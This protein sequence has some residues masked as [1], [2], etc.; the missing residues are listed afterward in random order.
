MLTFVFD[1]CNS[2]H[3]ENPYHNFRHAVDVLQSTYY[4]LCKIGVIDPFF[5]SDPTLQ[6]PD[7]APGLQI[8]L[9]PL[10]VFAILLASLGH[11]IGH[12]GVTNTFMV[13]MTLLERISVANMYQCYH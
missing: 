2:Y 10:D 9:R 5:D 4:F 8:L 3:Q 13:R 11:D 6:Q 1:V 12:P 7:N